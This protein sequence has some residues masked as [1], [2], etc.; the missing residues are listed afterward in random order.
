MTSLETTDHMPRDA[1]KI[2]KR[3]HLINKR[4]LVDPP[5]YT[6]PKSLKLVTNTSCGDYFREDNH[7][8][9]TE[10]QH[11]VLSRQGMA[12]FQDIMFCNYEKA[13]SVIQDSTLRYSILPCQAQKLIKYSRWAWLWST[14]LPTGS[15]FAE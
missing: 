14:W 7:T 13:H 8:S 2:A 9:R 1:K 11:R 4:C 15:C 10:T 3:D 12:W 5:N 6:T